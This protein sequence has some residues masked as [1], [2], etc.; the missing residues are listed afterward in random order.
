MLDEVPNGNGFGGN[1]YGINP[2]K[3]PDFIIERQVF[4]CYAP[5]S[6]N[7][8]N[9]LKMLRDKTTDQARRVVLNLNDYPIEKRAELIE[10]ILS[11]T[12]KDLKHLNE[13][14]VSLKAVK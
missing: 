14:L 10:F 7:L 9:I 8:K 12:H 4:D 11:Q 2:N 1:G 13:L 5:E 6:T 3:N